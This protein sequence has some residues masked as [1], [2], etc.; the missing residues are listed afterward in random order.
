[1]RLANC[2]FQPVCNAAKQ[3]A[4]GSIYK[5]GI[6]GHGPVVLLQFIP[7]SERPFEVISMHFIPK[8][9]ISQEY[10]NILVIVHK[11]TKYEIFVPCSTKITKIETT[12]LMFKHV[13]CKY[14]IPCQITPDHNVR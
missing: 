9:P 2:P 3:S 1:M 4:V 6:R 7:V 13:I 14:G 12:Q 8:L 10:N 11:L 5:G